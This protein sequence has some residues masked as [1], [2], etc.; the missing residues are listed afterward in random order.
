VRVLRPDQQGVFKAES[1]PPGAYYIAAFEA[2]DEENRTSPEFL[3]K[4][5][6]VAQQV[7]VAEGQNR[8]LTLRLSPLP[9]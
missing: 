7:T 8:T 5:R 2:L 9:Q 6:S 3:E 4:V 1:L